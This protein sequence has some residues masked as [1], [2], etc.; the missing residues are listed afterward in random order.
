MRLCVGD[1]DRYIVSW[2]NLSHMWIVLH[3]PLSYT[4]RNIKIGIFWCEMYTLWIVPD[5]CCDNNNERTWCS[6]D[7]IYLNTWPSF[8]ELLVLYTQ[9]QNCYRDSSTHGCCFICEKHFNC[10]AMW[11]RVLF[12]WIIANYRYFQC[13]L[14][15]KFFLL[16]RLQ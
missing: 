11:K 6:L 13:K 16:A 2:E 3:I 4:Y 8:N 5:C 12:E 7:V 14:H 9:I 15:L 10:D 1:L